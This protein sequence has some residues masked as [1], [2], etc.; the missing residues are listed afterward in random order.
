MSK[1]GLNSKEPFEEK[2]AT[3]SSVI[4][5]G[6]RRL[7]EEPD[8]LDTGQS[9]TNFVY[10]S[11]LCRLA[12][13]K[14]GKQLIKIGNNTVHCAGSGCDPEARSHRDSRPGQSATSCACS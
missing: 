12:S 6:A 13:E 9:S 5:S 1:S 14:H 11:F 7:K 10:C 3:S 2:T 8:V 4:L